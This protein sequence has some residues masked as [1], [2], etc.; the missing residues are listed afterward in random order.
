MGTN[1][2]FFTNRKELRDLFGDKVSIVDDPE[3]GYRIHVAKTSVGWSPIFEAHK[4][5]RSVADLKALYDHGGVRIFDE[6]NT[7][8]IWADFVNRVVE[9]GSD[10]NWRTLNNN[11]QNN[12]WSDSQGEFISVDGY[13]FSDYEFS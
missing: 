6:Y 4:T 3:F 9:F 2:Y 13:R 11:D 5:L 1:F 8:Y 10:R 12:V 7:E